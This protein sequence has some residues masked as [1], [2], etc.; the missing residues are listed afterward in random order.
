MKITT[1]NISRDVIYGFD[2]TEAQKA[3]F[4]YLDDIDGAS[5]FKYKGQ[6]Y[7]LGEFMCIDA[8]RKPCL[9]PLAGWDGYSS[10]SFF[11]GIVVK[12]VDDCERV[13]VGTYYA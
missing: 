9:S 11:S 10:D 6:V 5:F 3:E 1:N 8:K 4:D 7:D 13:I 2:L 12:Y